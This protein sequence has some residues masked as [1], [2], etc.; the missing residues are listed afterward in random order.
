MEDNSNE[1]LTLLA[2]DELAIHMVNHPHNK[3]RYQPPEWKCDYSRQSTPSCTEDE[4]SQP[5]GS[6]LK[7]TF[8]TI[9]KNARLGYTF[10]RD[11]SKCDILLPRRDISNVHF[12]VKF[13]SEGQLLLI[14][15]SSF[16]SWVSINDQRNSHPRHHFTWILSPDIKTIKIDFGDKHT[17]SFEL[18]VPRHTNLQAYQEK[19][20]IF[21]KM[22]RD[23]GPSLGSLVLDSPDAT[24]QPSRAISPRRRPWYLK[25]SEI[26][27]GQYGVVYKARDMST[28]KLYAIKEL[29]QRRADMADNVRCREIDIMESLPHHVS[30]LQPS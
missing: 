12:R 15:E 3:D 17:P 6:S 2:K 28:N 23:A 26:G 10:G 30:V 9:P 11:P 8:E 19:L 25:E 14:D 7:L 1:I 27:S 16:G 4:E 18:K 22:S 5:L 13:S 29:R 20:A 21:L 24:A